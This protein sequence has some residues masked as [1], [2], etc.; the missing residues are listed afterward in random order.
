[1][2]K[3]SITREFNQL[4]R[5]SMGINFLIAVTHFSMA[6]SNGAPYAVVGGAILTAIAAGYIKGGSSGPQ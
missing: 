6:H 1:M 4:E 3:Q 5:V 2:K